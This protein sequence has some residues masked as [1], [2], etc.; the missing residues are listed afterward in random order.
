MSDFM[1]WLI[2]N[3]LEI[4]IIVIGGVY[5][6]GQLRKGMTETTKR[7]NETAK[8]LQEHLDEEYPHYSCKLEAQK[9]DMILK[10]V[11]RLS[12]RFDVLDD[13]IVKILARHD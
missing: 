10:S 13:R 3:G 2:A 9:M 5:M 4:A 8:T 1:S 6:L 12:N 11:E 7:S